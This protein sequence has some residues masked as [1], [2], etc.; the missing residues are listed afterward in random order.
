MRINNNPTSP[1]RK[2]AVIIRNRRQGGYEVKILNLDSMKYGGL[3]APL[4]RIGVYGT[5]ENAIKAVRKSCASFKGRG[6]IK[7]EETRR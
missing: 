5:L 7:Q 1:F 2:Q 6:R 3:V 4:N